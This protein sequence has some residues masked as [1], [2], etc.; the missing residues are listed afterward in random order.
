MIDLLARLEP[1]AKVAWSAYTMPA[2]IDWLHSGKRVLESPDQVYPSSGPGTV[3][4]TAIFTV[5]AGAT[6]EWME[7]GW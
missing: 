2:Q 4:P 6:I 1:T 3:I 7:I 5:D